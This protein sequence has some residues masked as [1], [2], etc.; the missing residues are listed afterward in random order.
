MKREDMEKLEQIE[1]LLAKLQNDFFET[2]REI[3]MILNTMT[4]EAD[5]EE[6]EWDDSED[7][8]VNADLMER[9]DEIFGDEEL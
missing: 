4:E 7:E 9:M 1:G 2:Y 6:E 3:R 8:E 5:M